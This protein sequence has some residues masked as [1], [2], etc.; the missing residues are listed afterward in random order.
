LDFAICDIGLLPDEFFDMTWGNYNRYAYGFIKRQTKQ[1]EH[2]RMVVSMIYNTNVSKKHDQKKPEQIQPLWTDKLGK[3]KT[4]KEPP[5][6]KSDFQ[7]IVK[8]L[9]NNGK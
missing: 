1:W 9:D 8:K 6:S 7:D 3:K 4:T 5:I 2:T